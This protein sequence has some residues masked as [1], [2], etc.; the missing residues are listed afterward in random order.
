ML[1]VGEPD[2]VPEPELL[3]EPE[4]DPELLPDPE[5]EPEEP[6]L[7]PGLRFSVALAAR[8]VKAS[9]VFSPEVALVAC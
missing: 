7:W 3:P 2:P 9:M 4:P 5:P 1:D 6:E 8:A